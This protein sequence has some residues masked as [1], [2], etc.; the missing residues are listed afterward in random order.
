MLKNDYQTA[1][2]RFQALEQSY[3]GSM[4]N[5]QAKIILRLPIDSTDLA[6]LAK[7]PESDDRSAHGEIPLPEWISLEGPAPHPARNVVV[8]QLGTLRDVVLK[9]EVYDLAGRRR[10][11]ITN[12][13]YP[14]G[15]HLLKM[16]VTALSPGSYLLRAAIHTSA[17]TDS[18]ILERRFVVV[19]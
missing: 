15:V 12:Q 1:Y 11:A 16:D 7:L 17:H 14:A 18:I 19:R 13:D 5:L 10:M 8:F 2:S 9:A 3:A 6:A 4:E